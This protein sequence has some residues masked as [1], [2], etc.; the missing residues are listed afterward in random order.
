MFHGGFSWPRTAGSRCCWQPAGGAGRPGAGDE[1]DAARR[2]AGENALFFAFS[3]W[4]RPAHVLHSGCRRDRPDHSIIHYGTGNMAKKAV[5]KAAKKA[6]AKKAPAKPAAPK[7]I[8]EPL[9]KAG[10]VSHLADSTG[11][12]AKDVRSVLAALDDTIAGSLSKRGAG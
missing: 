1:P 12:A 3:Y 11:L 8:K 6:A 10:L 5:K 4:P 9:T 2:P 7:A